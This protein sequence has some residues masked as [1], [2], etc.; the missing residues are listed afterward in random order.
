LNRRS[1]SNIWRVFMTSPNRIAALDQ[2]R[3][4]LAT[5]PEAVRAKPSAADR[6]KH[7]RIFE[8]CVA[9]ELDLVKFECKYLGDIL[10]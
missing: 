2:L 7:A 10:V 5:I 6:Q 1:L 9:H 8:L 4:F 3:C